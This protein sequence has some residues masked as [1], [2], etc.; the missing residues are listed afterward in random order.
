MSIKKTL[1]A[2]IC[3]ATAFGATAAQADQAV[4]SINA[5]GDVATSLSVKVKDEKTCLQVGKAATIPHTRSTVTCLSDDG[6]IKSAHYCKNKTSWG[7]VKI[8]CKPLD[9]K[10]F[11]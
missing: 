10:A 7:N 11:Q 2:G 3:A 4:I 8:S 5:Y 6:V 9:L 1:A